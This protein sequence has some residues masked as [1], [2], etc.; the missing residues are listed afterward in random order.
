MNMNI[1]LLVTNFIGTITSKNV[2][3]IL[4]NEA[5]LQFELSTYLKQYVKSIN[6]NYKVQIERNVGYF[7]QN[8]TDFVKKEIDI[9]VF[10]DD[11]RY[12]IELKC[13][14]NGQYPEQ[15]YSFIKDLLFVQ[16]LKEA[17]F[18]DAVCLT[19]VDDHLFY[20]GKVGGKSTG[21]LYKV[22]RGGNGSIKISPNT[23]FF[24]P[25]GKQPQN[26]NPIHVLSDICTK[27]VYLQQINNAYYITG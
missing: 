10:N 6:G 22:F 16:Q 25:T 20:A 12:A 21:N 17:G 19:I 14:K 8:K 4:Y 9:V 11:E 2:N 5:G 1:E 23:L 27:W 15:M 3:D 13:P 26:N 18:N 24:K 7:V